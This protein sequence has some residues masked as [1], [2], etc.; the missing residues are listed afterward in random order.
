[1]LYIPV[2]FLQRKLYIRP[3]AVLVHRQSLSLAIPLAGITFKNVGKGVI[4]EKNKLLV[5][6]HAQ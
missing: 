6:Y 3:D 4:V 1:M 2:Y 5:S